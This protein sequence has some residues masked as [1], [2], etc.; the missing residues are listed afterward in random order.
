MTSAKMNSFHAWMNAK[1]PVATRP[2]GSHDPAEIPDIIRPI[3]QDLADLVI[4]SRHRGGSDEWQ[5]DGHE[6]PE[7]RR[8]VDHRRLLELFRHIGHEAAQ[9]PD[10]ER[11]DEREIGQGQAE[12][13]VDQLPAIEDPEQGDDQ[14][15]GRNHLHQQDADDEGPATPEPESRHGDGSH[16]DSRAFQDFGHDVAAPGRRFCVSANADATAL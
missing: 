11:Q 7:S 14:C 12:D 4:G 6:R 3:E 8:A 1:I 16:R 9:G 13:R 10:R 15:L 5:G 2:D